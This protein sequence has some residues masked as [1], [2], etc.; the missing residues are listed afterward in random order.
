[1]L[2]AIYAL[3][4]SGYFYAI[5]MLVIL[6]LMLLIAIVKPY[7]TAFSHCVT[8]DVLFLS[9]LA[10]WFGSVISMMIVE[11]KAVKSLLFAVA[12]CDILPLL[13]LFWSSTFPH[14][15]SQ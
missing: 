7:K 6:L 15:R 14:F 5:S 2:F 12:V 8:L 11:T 1:M 3:T 4:L 10:I 13:Y 9:V